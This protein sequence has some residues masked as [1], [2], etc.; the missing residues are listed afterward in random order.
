MPS[1]FKTFFAALLA[2]IVFS[3]LCLLV[4]VIFIGGITSKD[5]PRVRAKTV[6]V[7]DLSQDF[8][9]QVQYNPFALLTEDGAGNVP[10]LYDLVRLIHKAKSDKDIS[11]IYIQAN[12]NPNGFASGD[13]I[14]NALLDFK[15]SGKFILAH[16]DII[17]QKAYS[18]ANVADSIYLNPQ[19]GME[20]MGF[21]AELAFVKGTLDKLNIE[22]Q[23][24]YAGKFKSATEPL[25]T[26]RMTDENKLQTTV[27]LN[28]L[29]TD[30]LQKTAIA[31]K[32]DTAQLRQWANDAE[33]QTPRDALEKKLVD[34]LRYDDE[35]KVEIRNRLKLE[36][37]HRINFI[38]VNDY[39]ESG[40]FFDDYGESIALIYAQGDIVDGKAEMG[41]ISSEYYRN[42]IRTA[43]LDK[44]IKAIVFR[45]NSGGGSSLASENIWRELALAKKDKPVVV[46]FG[47]V[48][49]SGGYYIACAAD[50]IFAQPTTITG[51]IGVFGIIPNMQEFFRNKLGITFDGVK[52]GPYADAGSPYRPMTDRE[53]VMVQDIIDR[54]YSV[55]KQRVAD[56]RKKDT[57]YIDS[58]AQGR[59]WT[60]MRARDIGLIDRFGG[61]DDAIN[62]AATMAKLE[63]FYIR[64][65]PK[66]VNLF[67]RIF[68][69]ANPFD[70]TNKMK[71]E[72]GEENY[73]L[74]QELKRVK[75]MSNSIQARLPFQFLIR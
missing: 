15:K 41:V 63:D 50:S 22:P 28:D 23:I 29:Y 40:K 42:I 11:G 74:Y 56:G 14:R 16:G 2:L 10:G 35:V 38:R 72:M 5:K 70:Y 73:K 61:I 59:V 44:D 60:G 58:I 21:S 66:P 51:S 48:A 69:K 18:I 37:D 75:E 26:D 25:R 55:F 27:W 62:S 8:K 49:A 3:L 31:R 52:T 71:Q 32:L 53:K 4:M 68:K 64:E 12:Q 34:G 33:I 65:Y 46:S 1:F 54:T 57:L 20:W 39:M 17:T 47:D 24:F 45:I 36:K 7:L 13:E 9:E 43:R 30:F 67:D 6:I 19:G